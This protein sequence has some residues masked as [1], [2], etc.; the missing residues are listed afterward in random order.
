MQC[1]NCGYAS[2]DRFVGSPEENQS[3]KD[4]TDD[5][6]LWVKETDGRFWIP[7]IMTLP[8]GMLY[9]FDDNGKMRWAYAKMI[10]IPEDKRKDYPDGNGGFFTRMYDTENAQI[11]GE[12]LYA[13]SDVNKDAKKS[14]EKPAKIKLPKLKKIDGSSEIQSL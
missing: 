4:L 2:S 7:S 8:F 1:I 6:K 3:Y 5:M 10:D 14:Q 11:Y 13:I 9:P 12:F